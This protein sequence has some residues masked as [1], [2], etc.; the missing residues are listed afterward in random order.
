[1]NI[2]RAKEVTISE[3]DLE[4]FIKV[5]CSDTEVPQ[6]LKQGKCFVFS[7]GNDTPVEFKQGKFPVQVQVGILMVDR[8][9]KA[10]FRKWVFT[11]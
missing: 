3:A 9:A 8:K 7:L 11:V 5:A 1:M 2:G 6:A 4:E 10:V